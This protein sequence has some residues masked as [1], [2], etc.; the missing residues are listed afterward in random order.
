SFILNNH[1]P[2]LLGSMKLISYKYLGRKRT[3]RLRRLWKYIKT[4]VFGGAGTFFQKG[5][6]PPEAFFS[7]IT[8]SYNMLSSLKNCAA[9]IRDQEG[10]DFE[11]IVIDGASADGTAAWLGENPQIRSISEKDS[12]MYDAINKG[13]KMAG[14]DILAYLN[15]DEQYLPGTL[16]FVKEWFAKHPE[17]DIIFGDTLLIRPDGSLIAFRKGYR[18]RWIYIGA[19]HLYLQSCSMFF[20]RRIID[21]GFFFDTRFRVIGDEEFVVRLL[22]RGYRACHVG[23]FLAAF[24]MTG[25]N[26]SV[27]ERALEEKKMAA[28]KLPGYIRR[29]KWL[30]NGTRLMEKFLSGAYFM[31]KPITYEV[32]TVENETRRKSFVVNKASFRWKWQ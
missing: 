8:P 24:G 3:A 1:I 20:R 17:V 22:R 26:L 13:L 14:G 9:S 5:S 16:T 31:S 28:D 10:V 15:C 11:H 25:K 19:S 30:I 2:S 12:G 21:D 27:D 7:I 29:F 23:K 32:Y 4:K 6:C 18:P